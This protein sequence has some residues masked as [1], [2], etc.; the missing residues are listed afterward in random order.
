L[1]SDPQLSLRLPLPPPV[2]IL[3]ANVSVKVAALLFVRLV[4]VLHPLLER[5]RRRLE[6]PCIMRPQYVSC[7]CVR[8]GGERGR[9]PKRM[10]CDPGLSVTHISSLSTCR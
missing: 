6:A 4:R 8:G 7:A 2:F 3:E 9:V 10:S 1:D 5:A